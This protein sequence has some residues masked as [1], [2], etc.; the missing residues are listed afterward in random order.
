M[1]KRVT[2]RLVAIAYPSGDSNHHVEIEKEAQRMYPR[3]SSKLIL[4]LA[5]H[6]KD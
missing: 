5:N 3:T 1:R 6:E 4:K 2:A